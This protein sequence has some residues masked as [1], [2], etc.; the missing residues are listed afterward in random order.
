MSTPMMS[1]GKPDTT[2]QIVQ[3]TSTFD[4]VLKIAQTLLILGILIVLAVLT[5]Q[6]QNLTSALNGANSKS[7]PVAITNLP[8]IGFNG[9]PTIFVQNYPNQEF[10]VRTSTVWPLEFAYTQR[11]DQNCASD[12]NPSLPDLE[13]TVSFLKKKS[14]CITEYTIENTIWTLQG[15]IVNCHYSRIVAH[16]HRIYNSSTDIPSA[17]VRNHNHNGRH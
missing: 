7:L 11:W 4:K 6:L 17:G 8:P 15:E 9:P 1:E 13:K 16:V 14:R 12:P 2:Q 10:G 5:S 3:R